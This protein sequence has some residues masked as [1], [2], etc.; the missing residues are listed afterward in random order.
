M[1]KRDPDRRLSVPRAPLWAVVV[2][3]FRRQ[4]SDFQA[5]RAARIAYR[6]EVYKCSVIGRTHWTDAK[7]SGP[8]HRW[9]LFEAPNGKRHYEF[10]KLV[11]YAGDHHVEF[12]RT[13]LPWMHG[14]V[15]LDYPKW[16]AA[17]EER[18]RYV[19]DPA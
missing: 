2:G 6:T 13:V 3:W 12:T 10:T 14:V 18:L 17:M 5:W 11:S 16:R 1:S 4:W 7:Y 9:D 8:T 15:R 19:R